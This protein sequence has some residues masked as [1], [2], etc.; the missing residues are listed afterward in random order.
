VF[1]GILFIAI[2]VLHPLPSDFGGLIEPSSFLH[3]IRINRPH[4]LVKL[5][6]D[7]LSFRKVFHRGV[8][9]P[10]PCRKATW[11]E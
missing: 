3:K 2:H 8:R 6:Y 11:N 9:Y 7:Y 4:C 5:I 10:Y 1:I